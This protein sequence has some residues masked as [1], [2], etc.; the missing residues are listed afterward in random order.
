MQ[1]ATTGSTLLEPE[2]AALLVDALSADSDREQLTVARRS[3]V[4]RR[5][6][7]SGD[8]PD[9]RLGPARASARKRIGRR[10]DLRAR[11]IGY[12]NRR[13]SSHGS[14]T[15]TAVLP[16]PH[17]GSRAVRDA[18]AYTHPLSR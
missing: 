1:G 4:L 5:A 13:L 14:R 10:T 15:R 7:C 9:A 17:R 3:P 11:R 16:A 12:R 2:F 8:C 18:C 6:R